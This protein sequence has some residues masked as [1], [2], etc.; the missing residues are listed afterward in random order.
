MW[1]FATQNIDYLFSYNMKTFLFAAG[2]SVPF[3][4]KSSLST[5]HLT[6]IVTDKN[7]W[8][9]VINK[10]T[11]KKGPKVII[12]QP[13]FVVD[14]INKIISYAPNANFEQI[15]EVLDKISSYSMDPSPKNNMMNLVQCVINDMLNN[16]N[17]RLCNNMHAIP[18]LFRE[19]IAEEILELES[20]HKSSDYT[21][22]LELQK[23]FIT[24][25]AKKEKASIISTNYDNC[26]PNSLNG[27]DFDSCFETAD[28]QYPMQ[29]NIN[30]FMNAHHVVY[31]PHGHLRFQFTDNDNVTYWQDS[32]EANKKRWD[33]LNSSAIGSTLTST[34]GKY[35]YNFNTFITTGQTKDDSF[36]HLP[37]AIY[38]QRMACDIAN[39]D[40][41]YIIGYSFG[42]DHF[43]R[44]M[45]S[46]LKLKETN[47]VVIVDYYPNYISMTDEYTD[48]NN[49][50]LKIYQVFGTEW[51]IIY[52]TTTQTKLPFDQT[53][54]EKLNKDGFGEI[55]S[56]VYFYKKGY[57]EFLYK[58]KTVIDSCGV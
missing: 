53:E 1:C 28:S 51:P 46:F 34:I 47:K 23:K 33:S 56:K 8:Q 31:Y 37:Y 58:F 16:K 13:E 21:Q 42:D 25:A 36:N 29:I 41:V 40:I 19:I 11:S 44:L 15:A 6:Q 54:V 43:N 52:D 18:F 10:Y 48:Q 22:L 20:N 26:V 9:D 57:K 27:L 3:F 2:A 30:K 12:A 49:I 24:Y 32:T 4:E 35:A 50:I 5:K 45:K 39:S 55:F 14:V 38:Y 17:N 7:R